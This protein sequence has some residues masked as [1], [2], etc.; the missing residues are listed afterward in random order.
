[1][2]QD[3]TIVGEVRR[4][5]RVAT[6]RDTEDG[7]E[8]SVDA[9][10]TEPYLYLDNLYTV[11]LPLDAV[12]RGARF[13]MTNEAGDFLGETPSMQPVLQMLGSD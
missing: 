10:D 9:R 5:A 1:M 3:N 11:V 12:E 2:S 4:E 7:T 13:A 6:L 8:Y